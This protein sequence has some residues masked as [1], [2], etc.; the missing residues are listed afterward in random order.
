MKN[1]ILSVAF[2]VLLAVLLICILLVPDQETSLTERRALRQFPTVSWKGIYSGEWMEHLESWLPDQFPGR[3]T[4][5]SAALLFR[6]N[7]LMQS[8]YNGAYVANGKIVKTEYPLDEQSVIRLGQKIDALTNAYF[9]KNHVYCA[10]IPDKAAYLAEAS[11]HLS[12]DFTRMEQLLAENCHSAQYISLSKQL[13]A[14]DYYDTD[15]HWR[16]ER[17]LPVAD[18]LAEHMGAMLSHPAD[19]TPYTYTPFYG[20]YYAQSSGVRPDTLVYLTDVYTNAAIVDNLQKPEVTTVYEPDALGKMDSYDVFLSGAT[21]LLTLTNAAS[22]APAG[23]RT[24]ILF[25][26]SF[27][28]SL[29]PLLLSGYERIILVDLRYMS[30]ALLPDHLDLTN[31]NTT[32][33]LFLYG[34]QLANNSALLR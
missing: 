14:E 22:E 2:S 17:I 25:R 13:T 30:S 9:T 18:H 23:R 20:S 1:K 6:T 19:T 26:D 7:V 21:P 24:L 8:D 27:G 12:L 11:G 32:D 28:S 33:I 16:Q 3:E 10:L 4:F 5:R 31:P 15:I 29:A 34:T